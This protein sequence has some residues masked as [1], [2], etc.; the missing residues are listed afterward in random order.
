VTSV[1]EFFLMQVL[2]VMVVL[3]LHTYI[4]LH[5]IRRGIIFC[6]LVL[7]PLAAF[8]VMVA[9]TLGVAYGTPL[10]YALCGAVI[11]VAVRLAGVLV[12]FCF[13][14]IPAT[15]SALHSRRWGSCFTIAVAAG[16]AASLAGLPFGYFLDFSAGAAVALALGATL[17]ATWALAAMRRPIAR[18]EA[19]Q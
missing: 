5:I 17:F 18:G 16:V 15:V 3:V 19:R 9:I 6:D 11:T 8:G 4:G 10:S 2:L 13:L 1:I 7:D 12:V 14:I